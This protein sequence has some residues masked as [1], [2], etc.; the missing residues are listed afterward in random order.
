[1]ACIK[2]VDEVA[3]LGALGLRQSGDARI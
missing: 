2:E 1:V 3:D